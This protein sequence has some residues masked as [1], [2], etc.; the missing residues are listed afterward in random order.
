MS[1]QPVY[2]KPDV[3]AEPLF[4]Q[5]YAWPYLIAPA[6][7]AMYTANAHL[8]LM[9]SF[10]EAPEIHVAA[11][12]RPEML[13]G[14]FLGCDP[15]RAHEV[16]T[17]ADRISQEHGQ[18]LAFAEAVKSL[19]KL[20]EQDTQ[21]LSLEPLYAKIPK[22]LRGYV[23]LV[24]DSNNRP[25]FRFLEGLL[26]RS[27]FYDRSCQSLSLLRARGDSRPF[28]FSTP[29][30]SD[31]SRLEL[32]LPFEAPVLDELFSMRRTPAPLAPLAEKLGI[33]ARDA[34]RFASLFTPEAPAP[35]PAWEGPGTRIRYFGHA[36]LLFESRDVSILVDPVISYRTD[37]GVARYSFEDLP[38]TI[39]YVL[40]THNH[41]DHVLFETLLPLRHKVRQVIVPRSA[42]GSLVDPSLRLILRQLGFAQVLELGE[43]ES[44]SIPGGTL[45]SL[46]FLG[47]HGDLD[48]RTKSTYLL[49]LGGKRS[50][51]GADLN[52]LEPSFYEHVHALTGDVDR[53]FLGLECDGAPLS[54]L[55]GPLLC[56]PLGRKMDQSRR[57]NSSDF[58]KT[59]EL[60]ERL[61]P[62]EVYVYAMGQEPWLTHLTALQYTETSKPILEARRLIDHCLAQGRQPHHL[63]GKHDLLLS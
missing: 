12:Q 50:F 17:L 25:A 20:L 61:N 36:C 59:R 46:P 42:G 30:L 24:Y 52:N 1:S 54:W 13:G 39:D 49:E 33:A 9:R 16:K 53:L 43:F 41:Q 8:K 32:P 38:E 37:T 51:I 10:V 27:P 18:L 15:S 58:P 56:K 44:L 21:G 14:P 60:V 19:D 2:L 4:N 63:F 3:I 28:A 57:L 55:Y 5:W 29:R 62:R 23:E 11:L 40:L 7:A 48:I 22:L 45:T 6:S 47:E 34:E 35:R 26:Y 31:A